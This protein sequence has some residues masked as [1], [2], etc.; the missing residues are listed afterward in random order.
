MHDNGEIIMCFALAHLFG[1]SSC[2]DEMHRQRSLESN[3]RSVCYYLTD[4]ASPLNVN[5]LMWDKEVGTG[6]VALHR[7]V[8]GTYVVICPVAVDRNWPLSATSMSHNVQRGPRY[9]MIP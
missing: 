8:V 1:R 5:P 6:E 9:L 3:Q 2:L 7:Y 4:I